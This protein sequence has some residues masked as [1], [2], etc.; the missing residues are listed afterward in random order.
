MIMRA[1]GAALSAIEMLM[2][3]TGTSAAVRSN[4]DNSFDASWNFILIR[5]SFARCV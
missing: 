3:R 2:V 4:P 5:P 1:P